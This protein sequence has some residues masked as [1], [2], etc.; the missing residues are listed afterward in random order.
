MATEQTLK[1][2][3]DW[4]AID[5]KP[6]FELTKQGAMIPRRGSAGAAGLDL[7][8]PR[9]FTLNGGQH[10]LIKLGIRS[11][12]PKGW[13]GFIK[14]RSGLAIK[15]ITVLGGVIDSDYRGE[16][17]V[18]LHNVNPAIENFVEFNGGD[19]IAQVVFVPC[20]MGQAGHVLSVEDD[21][22][23]GAGGFGSTGA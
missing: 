6:V 8:T 2:N 17:G 18:I 4:T 22:E 13:V 14:D 9:K 23:R 19:R 21:T 16:W 5:P 20:F 12:F 11:R 15:G 10:T 7:F 3:V 1:V